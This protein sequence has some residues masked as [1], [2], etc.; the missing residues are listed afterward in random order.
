M[1]PDGGVGGGVAREA[2]PADHH[3]ATAGPRAAGREDMHRQRSD[4]RIGDPPFPAARHPGGAA[5]R[6]APHPHQEVPGQRRDGR[7][8]PDLS[9]GSYLYT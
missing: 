6:A 2:P 1:A 9:L 3:E 4:R 8:V 7:L 5:P